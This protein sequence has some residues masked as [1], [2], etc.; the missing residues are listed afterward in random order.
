MSKIASTMPQ[1]SGSE[2]PTSVMQSVLP[3]RVHNL[4]MR[5][6]LGGRPISSSDHAAHVTIRALE[7][8]RVA[9]DTGDDERGH[10]G[11]ESAAASI[12]GEGCAHRP[13]LDLVLEFGDQLGMP[14]G[15]PV[16]GVL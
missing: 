3:R 2:L 11:L 6:A 4:R 10:L 12:L 7:E 9:A 1:R 16:H 8:S 13:R 5:R 15:F 14:L